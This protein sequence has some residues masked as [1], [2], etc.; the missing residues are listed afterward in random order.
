MLTP[1][2]DTIYH[3]TYCEGSKPV[4]EDDNDDLD[5]LFDDNED[6]DLYGCCECYT[7]K[8]TCDNETKL[9]HMTERPTEDFLAVL[10]AL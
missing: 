8:D 1:T 10:E 3:I 5:D 7:L 9:K 2:T 4:C 6:Y